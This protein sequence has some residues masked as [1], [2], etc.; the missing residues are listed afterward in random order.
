MEQPWYYTGNPCHYHDRWKQTGHNFWGVILGELVDS[1]QAFSREGVCLAI[2]KI[3]TK[4]EI[5][6]RA[7]QPCVDYALVFATSKWHNS[8]LLSMSISFASSLLERQPSNTF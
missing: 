6:C 1:F 2:T 5:E 8:S 7:S 3:F 4:A